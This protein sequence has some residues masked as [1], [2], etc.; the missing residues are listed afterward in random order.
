MWPFD[1]SNEQTYQRYAQAYDARDYSN[2]DPNEAQDHVQ[3]FIQN[4]PPEAQRRVFEQ[5]FAQ[6]PANQRAELAQQFPPEYGVNPNDPRSMAQAMTQLGQD[7]PDMLQRLVNHPVLLA[8]TVGLAA[9]IGKHMLE[10]RQAYR[11]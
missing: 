5:H 9:L 4:A 8:G 3:R 1:Q 11:P 2:I 7:R 10:H 6:M